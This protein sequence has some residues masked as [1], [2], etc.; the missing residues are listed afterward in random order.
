MSGGGEVVPRLSFEEM[1]GEMSKYGVEITQGTLKNPTTEDMQG[2]YSMCIKHILN[3]DI[4]NIRIEE[5]TGDLKSSMPS[6]DGIQILPNEGKNHLQAI[7]NL[8]FI[9]HCEQVNKILCVENTLSYLFKPVSSHM[10]RLISAFVHF[11][12]YKEQIYVDNDMKIRR[13]EEGKSEDSALGAE[14]KAVKNELQSLQEN[15]EQVKNSVLSEKNKK[16]DYEEEIIENQNML[17]AQQSTIISLRAA[18]DKIVNE[19]NEIIFQFSRFRQKKEDLEDQI[20]P[21]PEKLQEYN[22]ELKNLLLEHVSYFEK[23][24][25]KNEEIKNKIN[26][27]DLCL[28]K[29]VDL[30]TILTGHF[31]ETIKLHIGKKE[32]LKGLEKHLKNL[33]SEKE[34]LTMKRK[35]QEKILL[36]TEQYFAQQKDKWNAKV[37][38]EEKNVAVVEEKAS[39]LYGQMDELKRQA[40]REAREIDSIVKLIQET[41]NNYRRNFALIDDLTAR[42]RSSHALLA[43]Q[44]RGQAAGRIG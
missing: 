28:K 40:D 32:E 8:R 1:R 18:K 24:K 38:A 5:F 2:V 3:K 16:R 13:I 9:R 11:T 12:K 30:V 25:K 42:T 7:G 31:N 27:S 26:I 39:Q 29:L 34:H 22:Q 23:D 44:V 33:K 43:A 4:N 17:N 10:A 21:S 19:T 6:I 35:Q 15:Y 36:E 20:V 14:L 37:Q 41:L